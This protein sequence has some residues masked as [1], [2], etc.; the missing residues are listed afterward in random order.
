MIEKDK[1]MTPAQ[2][3]VKRI[4]DVIISLVALVVLSPLLLLVALAV[5]LTSSGPALFHQERLGRNGVPF[6]LHKFR[7]MFNNAP[8]IRNPDGSTYSAQ[9]DP[10]VT[11]VGRF[12]RKTSL[13]ELPQ[14]INVL[15]GNMSLVGPRPDQVDQLSYYTQ[16]E[17][18]KL[19]VKPGITGLAQISGRNSIP[20][21][22]R[23]RLDLEY[24]ERQSLWLDVRILLR[25]IPYVLVRRDVFVEEDLNVKQSLDMVQ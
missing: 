11:P 3:A 19:Q 14:L 10:R 6:T 4:M 22:Q 12:L 24:V 13:D 2:A 15:E 25:T 9:D 7:S 8:D 18:R 5:R 21:E 23:K 1:N 20:W 17:K 16:E